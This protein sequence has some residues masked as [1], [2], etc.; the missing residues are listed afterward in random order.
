MNWKKGWSTKGCS[1]KKSTSQP[2]KST[3][4]QKSQL[5]NQKSQQSNRKVNQLTKTQL[6]SAGRWTLDAGRFRGLKQTVGRPILAPGGSQMGLDLFYVNFYIL[7][8]LGL[9]LCHFYALFKGQNVLGLVSFDGLG[10]KTHFSP[11]WGR[12][13]DDDSSPLLLS[14]VSISFIP[15]FT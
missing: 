3:V 15:L 5:V 13:G 4:K 9:V 1:A 10:T 12:F 2:E 11:L 7:F 14:R 6:T 8:G